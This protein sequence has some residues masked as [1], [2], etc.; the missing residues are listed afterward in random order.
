MPDPTVRPHDGDVP[1]T[2][3]FSGERLRQRRRELN[4]SVRHVA[5]AVN[6]S[7]GVIKAME[8]N[9]VRPSDGTFAALCNVLGI[10]AED[11]RARLMVPG[12]PDHRPTE[13]ASEADATPGRPRRS[14]RLLMARRRDREDGGERR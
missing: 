6:L 9:R 10:T 3:R 2:Q 13:W 12:P 1:F 11:G 8:R 7:P 5:L 4:L 14:A